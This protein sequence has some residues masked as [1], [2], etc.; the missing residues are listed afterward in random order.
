M[1]IKERGSGE[2]QDEALVNVTP[3]AEERS[4]PTV[5]ETGAEEVV[6]EAESAITAT[7]AAT[8]EVLPMPAFFP[9]AAEIPVGAAEI[10]V[11]AVEVEF[12]PGVTGEGRAQ[13]RVRVEAHSELELGLAVLALVGFLSFSRETQ[14]TSHKNPFVRDQATD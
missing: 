10:A 8:A 13:P 5:V 3:K 6:A 14:R 7:P 12:L 9:P 2:P 11:P 4:T 1:S